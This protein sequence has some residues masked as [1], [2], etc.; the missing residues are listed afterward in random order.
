VPLL[1]SSEFTTL[2]WALTGFLIVSGLIGV[3]WG[4]R[5]EGK[6]LEQIEAERN[7]KAL[8]GSVHLASAPEQDR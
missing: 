6:S 7:A 5:N 4:P 2:A 3:I 1:A 8:Q